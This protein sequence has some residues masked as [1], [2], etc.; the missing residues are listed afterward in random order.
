MAVTRA[1]SLI[2]GLVGLAMSAAA[3]WVVWSMV[4]FR[5]HAVRTD[6]EVI[7]FV[8]SRGSKGGTM[9]SPQVR[10]SIPAPEGGPGASYEIRGSVSSSSRSYEIGDR[11]PVWYQP[12]HP[13][14]GRIDSFM[15]QW[16][17]PL[18]FGFFGVVFGGI[19][20]GFIVAEWR[21]RRLYAWL[22]THGMT[23]Q[24]KL[25]EVGRNYNL[26]VNGRS[27]WVLRA[28]WQH[29]VTHAVHVFES[30]YLW[31]D[32]SDYVGE[33]KEVPVRVDADDPGRHRV[34]ISWLPKKG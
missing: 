15:E 23:V 25:L 3:L 28:Q 11:V 22:A 18:I 12:E 16:F 30:E 27:P 8:T 9:Y 20:T 26:K 7:G 33:R 21:Q 2:F 5:A 31:Y 14:N 29:P 13:E 24:A 17:F 32:P 10:Y 6:G 4:E 1:I 34:D 19:A